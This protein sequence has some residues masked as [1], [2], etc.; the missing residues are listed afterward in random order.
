MSVV[1]QLHAAATGVLSRAYAPY[2]N[3]P[4]AVAALDAQGTVHTGVNIENASY[5]LTQCAEVAMIAAW[6]MAAGA[7]LTHLVCINADGEH[8]TP[9]GRCRQVLVE[10][11]TGALVIA[12]DGGST[13]LAELLPHAFGPDNLQD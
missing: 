6:R 12:L 3:Y 8:I 10:H 11:A 1:E 9:C 13:T 7:P 2:S 5:G 4:V